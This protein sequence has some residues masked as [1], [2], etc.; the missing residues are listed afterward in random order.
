VLQ[1]IAASQ[2][3]E[4]REISGRLP[5]ATGGGVG[6]FG[7]RGQTETLRQFV[8]AAC[9]NELGLQSPGHPQQP[10]P[11]APRYK[12]KGDDLTSADIEALV[13][14]VLNLP[15]PQSE[16][17]RNTNEATALGQG[18]RIFTRIGCSACHMP[19]VGRVEGLFS[20]LLLHDMGPALEDPVKPNPETRRMEQMVS[21]GYSGSGSIFVEE[22]IDTPELAREW[23]TPPLWGV[24][25][26]APYL[27]DGRAQTLIE[28]I[29][30]HGG[31]AA[32]AA[33]R[34]RD[35][36]GEERSSLIFFL[37]SLVAPR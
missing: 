6:R 4:F 3:K 35:L 34:F 24:A 21:F 25:D 14:F 8:L 19:D 11:L 15:R 26:S 2:A 16:P 27:H 32:T 29:N 30:L 7:W 36:S 10:N 37:E 13:K 1:E 33:Q 23:R 12:G 20:D 5:R 17:A 9:A 28:A 18:E 22:E 31:E